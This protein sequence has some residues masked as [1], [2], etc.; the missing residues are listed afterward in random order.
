[1]TSE[2][3]Q[4]LDPTAA[5]LEAVSAAGSLAS[6]A[7]SLR[8]N[9]TET[10]GLL[11][12]ALRGATERDAAILVLRYLGDSF[13]RNLVGDL[14]TLALS[15]RNA[16]AARQ[17]LGQLSHSDSVELVPPAVWNQ[18]DETGDY[19]AYRRMAELLKHLGLDAALGGLC[20]RAADSDD[21]DIREVAADFGTVQ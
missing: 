15:H 3:T 4:D 5:W 13:I 7:A 8:R 18:L 20:R 14:V 12:N 17:L 6:A 1:M 21:E 11:G 2:S 10:V 9:E 16:L 19:D